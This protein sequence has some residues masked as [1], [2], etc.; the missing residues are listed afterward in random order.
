MSHCSCPVVSAVDLKHTKYFMSDTDRQ[1]SMA[2]M[3]RVTNI[4][5]YQHAKLKTNFNIAITGT[6]S[7][8]ERAARVRACN[9]LKFET[10]RNL[11]PVLKIV[12]RPAHAVLTYTIKHG[13]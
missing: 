3:A 12:T 13:C 7:A 8:Q 10:G 1:S 4:P 11:P 2:V 6:K 5:L 9:Y